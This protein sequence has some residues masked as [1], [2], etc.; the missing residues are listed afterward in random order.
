MSPSLGPPERR[1]AAAEHGGLDRQLASLADAVEL[2]DGRLEPETV[3]AARAVVARAGRR[4]GLG[5]EETVVALAGP[6]GAGKSSLFNAVA[7]GELVSAGRRRPT[8]ATATAAVWGD[9]AGP[10]LDWLEIP[11][12]HRL[13]SDGLAGLVLLDLPDFDSVETAHRVEVDRVLEL[14]D[15]VVWI[16]DPQKYADASL[17]D[18]YLRPLAAYRETMLVVLNQADLLDA[19]AL[20]ACRRD[21][22]RLLQE[23]GL[24]GVPVLAASAVA[25]DGTASLRA[26]LA[27]RVAAREAAVARLRADVETA[28]GELAASCGGTAHGVAKGDRAQLLAALEEAAG[29]PAVVRAVERAHKRHGALATGWPLVRWAK[30]LRPDPLRRLH[31]Q[32][33]PDA[34]QRTSLPVAT[35]VQR[36]EVSAAMRSLASR[37]SEGLAEP[38]PALVR[39]A[40]TNAEDALPDRLDRAVAGT[41][42]PRGTPRWWSVFGLLQRGLALVAA[43]GALWLLVLAAL[44]YLQLQDAVPTPDLAGFPLPT[45][46][47]LGGLL[48]GLLLAAATR[49][50]NGIG[51][52]RRGR[53]AAK[54]LRS[55]VEDVADDAIL[56]PVRDELA[57]HDALCSALA[58]AYARSGRSG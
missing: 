4:L 48:L 3:A 58:A 26:A 36:A 29:V 22:G 37:A 32:E 13:A 31:L 34:A 41:E 15:L 56:T 47:L 54:A 55:S 49:W 44:G 8:T 51:A 40:A 5:V 23:D 7:G 30:R 50:A 43:A 57:A 17:H 24:D 52:R 39:R 20:A 12:R 35:G 14:A 53:R 38:W 1:R 2:A 33:K 21:L 6:T 25:G 10:L 27:E 45:V 16:V 9:G 19:D 42:L 46:L 28:A 11:R 18:R